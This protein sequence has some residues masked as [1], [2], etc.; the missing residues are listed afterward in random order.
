MDRE[1]LSADLWH[2]VA[3]CDKKRNRDNYDPGSFVLL[4]LK[5]II[6]CPAFS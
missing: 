6:L 4:C 5:D 2:V 3:I 1:S